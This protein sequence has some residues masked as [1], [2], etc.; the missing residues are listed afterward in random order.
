MVPGTPTDGRSHPVAHQA[1]GAVVV[2]GVPFPAVLSAADVSA[3]HSLREGVL[4][5][6]QPLLFLF[7]EKFCPLAHQLQLRARL[8]R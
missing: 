5:S 1:G 3:E 8:A 4:K 7:A 2:S 6:H